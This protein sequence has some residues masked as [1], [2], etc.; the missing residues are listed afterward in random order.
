MFY[1]Y[2]S[3][4][5]T[6]QILP[7]ILFLKACE[8]NMGQNNSNFCPDVSD[9]WWA[10]FIL[11]ICWSVLIFPGRIFT[12]K[13]EMFNTNHQKNLWSFAQFNPIICCSHWHYYRIVFVLTESFVLAMHVVLTS[14][15][16]IFC[17]NGICRILV[18]ACEWHKRWIESHSVLK[19]NGKQNTVGL[20][21]TE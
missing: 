12:K 16:P 18:F 9:N 5:L 6:Q 14:W 2:S 8:E 3:I 11:N 15:G 1:F 7:I 20:N 21:E 19:L 10:L 17:I 13:S 4:N